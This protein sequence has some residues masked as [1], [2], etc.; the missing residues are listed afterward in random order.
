MLETVLSVP[1]ET[2]TRAML[3]R[4]LALMT[5]VVALGL[6]VGAEQARKPEATSLL[7]KPLYAAEQPPETRA[8]LEENLAAAKKELEKAPNSTEAAIWVARSTMSS[9]SRCVSPAES[10]PSRKA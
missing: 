9:A 3:R 7:G 1:S 10:P 4:M 2:R 8:K 6:S 5:M